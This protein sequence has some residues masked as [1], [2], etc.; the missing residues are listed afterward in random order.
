MSLESTLRR[1][2]SAVARLASALPNP[3]I[4]RQLYKYLRT[5]QLPRGVD[6]SMPFP[7][8]VKGGTLEIGGA[9]LTVD[10]IAVNKTIP[11]LFS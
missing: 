1:V 4:E 6:T 5:G 11:G 3:H 10:K 7:R 2:D 8:F 9:F